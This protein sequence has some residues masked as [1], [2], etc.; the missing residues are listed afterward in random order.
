MERIATLVRSVLHKSSQIV[1][2]VGI[3]ERIGVGWLLCGTHCV[4]GPLVC[5]PWSGGRKEPSRVGPLPYWHL[6]GPHWLGHSSTSASTAHHWTDRIRLLRDTATLGPNMNAD[7]DFGL[8]QHHNNT[9]ISHFCRF[10]IR[11]TT[12]LV[13]AVKGLHVKV[14]LLAALY[15][16]KSKP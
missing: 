7:L 1:C 8:Q 16:W 15:R 13:F 12:Y 9:T 4:N 3:V 5:R 11:C 14:E 10:I 6:W 2:A